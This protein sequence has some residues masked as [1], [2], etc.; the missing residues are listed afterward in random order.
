MELYFLVIPPYF[1]NISSDLIV[2]VIGLFTLISLFLGFVRFLYLSSKKRRTIYLTPPPFLRLKEWFRRVFSAF[3]TTRKKVTNLH[4]A[5]INLKEWQKYIY[6]G[7]TQNF[8]I[9]LNYINNHEQMIQE[10]DRYSI[11]LDLQAIW[12]SLPSMNNFGV[13]YESLVKLT[14]MFPHIYVEV[15]LISWSKHTE[16]EVKAAIQHLKTYPTENYISNEWNETINKILSLWL[17]HDLNQFPDW[18]QNALID[19]TTSASFGQVVEELIN[20]AILYEHEFENVLKST[21]ALRRLNNQKIFEQCIIVAIKKKQYTLYYPTIRDAIELT[22]K[23]WDSIPQEEVE[24]AIALL[25]AVYNAGF[26]S[27]LREVIIQAQN[28]F[29]QNSW[30]PSSIDWTIYCHEFL[31]NGEYER[32]EIR[33]VLHLFGPVLIPAI[34]CLIQHYQNDRIIHRGALVYLSE[35]MLMSDTHKK[36]M[37]KKEKVEKEVKKTKKLTRIT[38]VS[39]MMPKK[40]K[41]FPVQSGDFTSIRQDPQNIQ[42]LR[43]ICLS[44]KSEDDRWS[45][46]EAYA[47]LLVLQGELDKS[48]KSNLK[49]T[50]IDIV[51]LA[52]V[53]FQDH[54]PSIMQNLKKVSPQDLDEQRIIVSIQEPIAAQRHFSTDERI[55]ELLQLLKNLNESDLNG[56]IQAIDECGINRETY[57][58]PEDLETTQRIA[59][60]WFLRRLLFENKYGDPTNIQWHL[61]NIG[62]T[63]RGAKREIVAHLQTIGG[64]IF[65][66]LRKAKPVIF[67]IFWFISIL[68]FPYLSYGQTKIQGDTTNQISEANT[69][70]LNQQ[71]SNSLHS[72]QSI[73]SIQQ[74]NEVLS[75]DTLDNA[76]NHSSL[77]NKQAKS[78]S[79]IAIQ[80][81]TKTISIVF[82]KQAL[83]TLGMVLCIVLITIIGVLVVKRIFTWLFNRREKRYQQKLTIE[84]ALNICETNSWVAKEGVGKSVNKSVLEA[85]TT[86]SEIQPFKYSEKAIQT[87]RN[88]LC[89]VWKKQDLLKVSEEI[90]KELA[91][92][93][94]F[95]ETL[96]DVVMAGC[97]GYIPTMRLGVNKA[98]LISKAITHL[99]KLNNLKTPSN[100]QGVME[101]AINH[102][103]IRCQ[104]KTYHEFDRNQFFHFISKIDESLLMSVLRSMVDRECIAV[105]KEG[106]N[107]PDKHA[108][109]VRTG[110]V[111]FFTTAVT[112]LENQGQILEN[113]KSLRIIYRNFLDSENSNPQCYL[114]ADRCLI[115]LR[116]RVP[117]ANAL[118]NSIYNAIDNRLQSSS[119]ST[120]KDGESIINGTLEFLK[121]QQILSSINSMVP[122]MSVKELQKIYSFYQQSVNKLKKLKKT[123]LFYWQNKAKI[124]IAETLLSAITQQTPEI[125]TWL[126]S[127]EHFFAYDLLAQWAAQAFMKLQNYQLG[128]EGDTEQAKSLLN[129]ILDTVQFDSEISIEKLIQVTVTTHTN[130]ES[131]DLE[132]EIELTINFLS[133]WQDIKSLENSPNTNKMMQRFW[134]HIPQEMVTPLTDYYTHCTVGKQIAQMLRNHYSKQAKL[135]KL[136]QCCTLLPNDDHKRDN[137]SNKKSESQSD[138]DILIMII[139]QEMYH[140]VYSIFLDTDLHNNGKNSASVTK[141]INFLN[142]A[143]HFL[144]L[145]TTNQEILAGIIAHMPI[146][147]FDTVMEYYTGVPLLKNFVHEFNNYRNSY[148]D[149]IK[150]I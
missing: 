115:G 4:S 139:G 11:M 108:Y 124:M 56:V 35:A 81:D 116:K 80:R 109:T 70:S 123:E 23:A 100:E 5:V 10:H 96:T 84:Q 15:F 141:F 42:I 32:D 57:P 3:S 104:T 99:Q 20:Q 44:S 93:K 55:P 14:K 90:R 106:N 52:D 79:F 43:T 142:F 2:I 34:R 82:E 75:Y 29:R 120:F 78:P 95:I 140:Y 105:K 12:E 22:K 53:L 1:L 110:L 77:V 66:S 16:Q 64:T 54:L 88:R 28:R 76:I 86:I 91:T 111:I 31:E 17:H 65:N 94:L 59:R 118:F 113:I 146:H 46:C 25:E 128:N 129:T 37:P 6:G 8:Q 58:I 7:E 112:R 149:T 114:E 67:L 49:E 137:G 145:D 85:I 9:V 33:Q 89:R 134:V 102:C 138:E 18:F 130:Q 119:K 39:R 51:A 73:T 135:L 21:A 122:M 147:D 47:T 24:K 62:V 63:D 101:I 19:L 150:K 144:K 30:S 136:Q 60:Y 61:N 40:K 87:M 74:N 13:F 132:K 48:G 121:T 131:I 26:D 107:Q 71:K 97:P 125:I 68:A 72:D 41:S 27:S 103:I 148:E 69:D 92:C 143:D 127:V 126:K 50:Q 36:T 38:S 98:N 117:N 133:F 45:Y 83:K